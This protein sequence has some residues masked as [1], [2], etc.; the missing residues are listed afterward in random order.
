MGLN[1]PIIVSSG[2]YCLGVETKT[3]ELRLIFEV[4][5]LLSCL[6][7]Y[8]SA[9]SLPSSLYVPPFFLIYFSVSLSYPLASPSL[10]T[11]HIFY[12]IAIFTQSGGNRVGGGRGSWIRQNCLRR[13]ENESQFHPNLIALLPRPSR[14]PG[15]S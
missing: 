14:A 2:F 1:L 13:D 4:F 10:A 9:S 5:I 7:F 15:A 8:A 11:A 6:R 3:L 12:F